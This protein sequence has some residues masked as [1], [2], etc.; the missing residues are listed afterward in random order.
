MNPD[1]DSDAERTTRRAFLGASAKVVAGAALLPAV[2]RPGYAAESNTIQLALIG[3]GGRG[4]GAVANA[5]ATRSGPIRLVAMADLFAERLERSYE[6]LKNTAA[7]RTEGT[8]D[9]W[10]SGFEPSQVDVLPER[11]FV[12]FDAYREAMDCLRPGDVAILT[13]P[14][15]FR[16][17]HFAYAVERGLNVFMEK[18]ISVDGPTTR[19]MLA[20]GERATAKNL[21]VGVGLMC[22]HCAAREELHGR[23][24]AGAI[25]PIMA[26]RSYRQVG[27]AGFVGPRSAQTSELLYQVRNYLGFFWASGGVFHDYIAHNVDEC[28]WM[29][30][31]W[32]VRAQGQGARL[33]RGNAVDQNFDNYSIE[34]TFG[35]G[36]KLFVYSRYMAGCHDEFA[37]Y[38]MGTEGSAVISTFVHTPARC[39]LFQG[40]NLTRPNLVWA[41]PQPEPNPYEREWIHLVDAIRRDLPF[42]EVARGAHA[43][44]TVALGRRAVHTGQVIEFD[45]MLGSDEEFAPGVDQLTLASDAPVQVGAD[46]L[47]PMPE[48]G[49]IRD[50]EYA[51]SPVAR[52]ADDA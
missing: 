35:D 36:T 40:H 51:A 2:A 10:V 47:Y 32:P 28:C 41:Y 21:K 3:C 44:L 5:L 11:R 43:S 12:G 31:A 9:A 25:G 37:S 16:W 39:R 18:P 50:R 42:N 8:A 13:A 33:Y 46:G 48:P 1:S 4:T 24:D 15:A 22:R 29:K 34:Y 17:V 38:A 30:N 26:M 6:T 20:L 23:I 45:E 19:R 14:V 27:P 49:R 7:H 52:R